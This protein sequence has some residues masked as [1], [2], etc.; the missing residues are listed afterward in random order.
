MD[1]LFL[2]EELEPTDGVIQND[3]ENTIDKICE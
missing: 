2:N 3:P 1:N